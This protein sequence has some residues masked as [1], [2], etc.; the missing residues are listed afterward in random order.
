MQGGVALAGRKH[1]S[2]TAVLVGRQDL[3]LWEVLQ[4]RVDAGGVATV[5]SRHESR[6]AVLVG[7]QD[8]LLGAVLQQRVDPIN[9]AFDGSRMEKCMRLRLLDRDEVTEPGAYR[10]ELD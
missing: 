8:L 3:L 7:R 9:V 6:H 10:Q 5:A 2:R 1:E 4:Q